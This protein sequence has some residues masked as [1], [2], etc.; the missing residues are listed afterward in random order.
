MRIALRKTQWL[1]REFGRDDG[2]CT[3]LIGKLSQSRRTAECYKQIAA[4]GV[5]AGEKTEHNRALLLKGGAEGM[6]TFMSYEILSAAGSF[7]EYDAAMKM[8]KDYYGGMLSL[9][10]TTF[11]EDFDLRWKKTR[12][13]STKF[14]DPD[15]KT[16]TATMAHSVIKDSA[17]VS[18]MA[19][20]RE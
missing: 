16:Y 12:R 8:L 9:G 10:T 15:K 5:W 17:T 14:R 13:G 6:S 2:R 4:L 20:R 19:G 3:R 11:W 1:L 7:G 18:A